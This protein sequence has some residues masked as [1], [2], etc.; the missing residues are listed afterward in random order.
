[1]KVIFLEDVPNV[2]RAGE[3]K[4]VANGYG[5]NYLIPHKLAALADPQA[6]S[7]AEAPIR[8]RAH[9]EAQT[10]SEMGELASE[11][12]G[13]EITLKAKAGTKDRLYGS[14][15]SAD[16]ASELENTTG[17]VVDKKKIEIA[18]PIR[19]LGSHEVSIRL[20]K[21][22]IPKITVTVIEETEEKE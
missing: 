6:L 8:A 5:R 20:A 16:I 18:E 11:L 9:R 12:D 10:E 22:I 4:E 7:N 21:D 15:T 1:M 3:I 19:Q 13:K 17:A 14:I 2:A